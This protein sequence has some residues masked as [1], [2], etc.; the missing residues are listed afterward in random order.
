MGHKSI[1]MSERYSHLSPEHKKDVVKGLENMLR[2][3]KKKNRNS[4][5]EKSL[6]TK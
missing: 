2:V 6:P 4:P 3:K 1:A 5:R